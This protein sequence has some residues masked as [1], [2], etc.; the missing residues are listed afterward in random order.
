MEPKRAVPGRDSVL[1][2][3]GALLVVS[4]AAT[5]AL[6]WI[7]FLHTLS[8]PLRYLST[9][10][11][12]MGH[13]FAAIL[14]GGEFIDFRMYSD[15]SGVARNSGVSSQIGAAIV[16]AGGL[17]GPA[18]GAAVGFVFARNAKLGR[19]YLGLIGA[20]LLLAELLWVRNTFGLIFVG[21]FG[22]VCVIVAAQPY[23]QLAQ[24][25]LVFLSVQLA[26]SVYSGG[27]Y[28]FV[29]EARTGSGTFPSDV[30]QMADALFGPYWL[31]GAV[32]AAFSALVLILG[33]SRM[34]A[35]PSKR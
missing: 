12:E 34:L 35:R 11:H 29:E 20:I 26:L 17:V 28:L 3:V 16:S 13:G 8:L 21:G 7:P 24:L 6:Y 33:V 30:A 15:G 1:S 14:V 25:F 23:K 18:V 19:A 27:G 9:M 10:V 4:I 5:V 22:A 31:W 2:S 32:C